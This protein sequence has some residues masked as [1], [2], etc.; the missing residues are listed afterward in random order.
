MLEF[1]KRAIPWMLAALLFGAGWNLGSN[2]NE[3]KWQ[4]VIHNE[5]VKKQEATKATQREVSEI[6]SKYQ[7]D[8]D[9]LEGSTDRIIT[10][11]RGSNQRLLVKVK[12][13]GGTPSGDGRCLF[14]GK[15]ELDEATSKRL[16][17]IA[18]KGDLQ[19]E[20]LQETIRKLQGGPK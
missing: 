5:Y 14:D 3:A 6:S 18:Q 13:L 17:G 19:I 4:E 12:A 16:I 7:S 9:G 1:L 15:A 20:A 2:D 10:D 8:L 11:L